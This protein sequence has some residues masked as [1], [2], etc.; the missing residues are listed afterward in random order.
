MSEYKQIKQYK[1]TPHFSNLN[2]IVAEKQGVLFIQRTIYCKYMGAN[3]HLRFFFY[4]NSLIIVFPTEQLQDTKHKQQQGYN[5]TTIIKLREL[6]E[7]ER[8]GKEKKYLF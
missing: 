1:T 4:C 7:K 8:K 3:F 6:R 2:D 5:S